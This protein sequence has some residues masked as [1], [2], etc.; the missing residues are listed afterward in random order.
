[1][2]TRIIHLLLTSAVLLTTA[3]IQDLLV[4][5]EEPKTTRLTAYMEFQPETKTMLSELRDGRYYPL[6]A[7]ND[8]IA[9]FTATG[10]RPAPF[11]LSSGAGETSGIFEGPRSGDR[12]VALFPFD[13]QAQWEDNTLSFRI[14][15]KQ[16][17][18][19][20]SFALN[21][22]PMIAVSESGDLQFK[23]LCSVM[24]L[25]LTGSGVVGS[26]TLH[27]GSHFLSGPA[28]VDLAYG[29]IPSLE[30]KEGGSHEV[31]L[32]CGAVM[33][34]KDSAKDF[35]IVIPSAIYEGLTITVD[36][37]TE[38]VTK[39]ISHD[40]T[41]KRSELRPVT[42]FMVE[43]PMM[44]LDNLPDNQVWYK[45]E[46]G[47]KYSP[48]FW[49][50]HPP[51]DANMVSHLYE[52]G[53]GIILFD[54]PVK[55]VHELAF[56]LTPYGMTPVTELHLPD[57]VETIEMQSLPNNMERFRVPG[58]IKNLGL[59][60]LSRV[61]YIY[62][63]PVAADGRSVVSNGTLL[64]VGGPA[65][66]EYHTP[67]G[68]QMIASNSLWGCSFNRFFISEGVLEVK[69]YAFMYS[70][71]E[72]L[73]F[74]ESLETVGRQFSIYDL[75][76]FYGNSRFVSED[77]LSLINPKGVWGP[78]LVGLAPD[79]QLEYFTIPEGITA[80]AVPFMEWQNLRRIRIPDTFS[81]FSHLG[82]IVGCPNFEGFDG[83][84]ISADGRCL[85]KNG[86]V[87]GVFTGGIKEYTIPA[88]V[89]TLG[90]SCL[91][92][93]CKGE[94]ESLIVSEGVQELQ[95]F[96]FEGCSSLQ[97]VTLPTTIKS[98]GYLVFAGDANLESVYL[99]VRVPP[100]VSSG[101]DR[102]PLPKLKVYV[103]EESYE[104][105]MAD[106]F[107]VRWEQYLTPYHFD[108]IDPPAAYESS[109]FS[110]DGMVTVLQTASEGNG[111][112]LVLMGDAFSDRMIADGR[113][114]AA[115]EKMEEAFF[116]TEPFRAFRHLFNVYAV[117]VVSPSE[118]YTSDNLALDFSFSVGNASA[119]ANPDKSI[120]YAMKAIPDERLEE[121][122]IIVLG[123]TFGVDSEGGTCYMMTRS[124][125][126]TDYGSGL[127]F[128]VFGLP[129][130]Q[131]LVQ[132][133]AGGHGFAKLQDEYTGRSEGAVLEIPGEE[134]E[135]MTE[136]QRFGWW[137]NVDFT[138][139]PAQVRW[140]Y[141]LSDSRYEK[142]RLGIY[143][144]AGMFY[145]KGIY[146]SSEDG[147][148]NS[149]QGGFNAPSR[150]AIYYRIH[151]LAYGPDWEYDYEK[152]VEYDQGAKNI[153]PTAAK[154][155]PAS[156]KNYE[157]RDPLPVTSFNPKEWTV[158]TME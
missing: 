25:S 139:D 20:N 39:S 77:H 32:E 95:Q 89:K 112:D 94:V 102:T 52:G 37:Y 81:F 87:K 16:S 156:R 85:I 58:G 79:N 46:G 54:G 141:F 45:T 14:P 5:P 80:I 90:M 123:N 36:A 50:D 9:V 111:I 38:K 116:A 42:P 131:A 96:C 75:K 99:P 31:R 122:T 147:I 24:R 56:D 4:A 146:R 107:W 22:F 18:H 109:D 2:K 132:H 76:G 70:H 73:Y 114:L 145:S 82:I 105:Y 117:N 108:N 101:P 34:D 28:S 69:D 121:A 23:N 10:Q 97:S 104:D 33:L 128:A 151:K 106:S 142:E 72:E 126:T 136:Q 29:D 43:A 66:E 124:V 65:S 26:I 49:L 119:S 155:A 134:I 60:N 143:E 21:G 137:K 130:G 51:F 41:L 84:T 68:V 91:Y 7:E 129:W 61:S 71:I 6:W 17:Y 35:Y 120:A 19:S 86:V 59:G 67:E 47:T 157:V 133:E 140:S 135:R 149:G 148:M 93:F 53:Y 1:M 118:D 138:D 40:V 100:T 152:F 113:Y 62:G 115:M 103:P 15:E 158:T 64:G 154:M 98:I 127:G 57:C 3:C 125:P 144:G 110:Q 78:T 13:S 88:D 48:D 74:P 83:P 153:R 150:E 30:M 8:S 27:S 63:P 44:D 12:Y 55:T 92:A 11:I